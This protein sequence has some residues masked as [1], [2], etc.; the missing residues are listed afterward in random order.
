M[1]KISALKLPV[2]LVG[3]VAGSAVLL[4]GMPD[5]VQ[6]AK[7]RNSNKNGASSR[8]EPP[9]KT[10]VPKKGILK[11]TPLPKSTFSSKAVRKEHARKTI[12]REKRKARAEAAAKRKAKRANR[13]TLTKLAGLFGTK[14]KT[15]V[16]KQTS[17]GKGVTFNKVVMVKIIPANNRGRKVPR[18]G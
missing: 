6:A 12:A 16:K 14:P 4:T 15:R 17:K 13:S 3:L 11:K 8:K 9:P 1:H 5:S 10:A 2:L 18:R 7:V